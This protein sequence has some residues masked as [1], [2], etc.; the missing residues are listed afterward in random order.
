[1][2]DL[3]PVNIAPAEE[4]RLV[5]FKVE[6]ERREGGDD[7]ATRPALGRTS[8]VLTADLGPELRGL[9]RLVRANPLPELAEG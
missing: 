2:K 5:P 1:M 9:S 3:E 4:H 7:K 8:F 6:A